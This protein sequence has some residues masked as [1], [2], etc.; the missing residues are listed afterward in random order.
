M[1]TLIVNLPAGP[2]PR[3]E[4]DYVLSQ[5][6]VSPHRQ[7]SAAATLLPTASEVIAVLPPQALS[8]HVVHLPEGLRLH[9]R[10]EPTRL[11]AALAGLIEEQLLDEPEQLHLAVFAHHQ[12]QHVWAAA[13]AEA[14]LRAQLDTLEAAGCTPTRVVPAYLPT[15][16]A[17]SASAQP[18]TPSLY[19]LGPDAA[20]LVLCHAQGVVTLPGNE[21]AWRF[22][23]AQTPQR[24]TA[25][26]AAMQTAQGKGGD[27]TL[28]TRAQ[29]LLGL[30]QSPCNLA[31]HRLA[32]S[33]ARRW[34]KQ[35]R[36][37]LAALWQSR[38]WRPARV[39]LALLMALNML[40]LSLV[41]RQE[42]AALHAKQERINQVLRNT[43]PDVGLVIDA[44]LQMA[45]AL[46]RQQGSTL[47]LAGALQAMAQA[48]PTSTSK[49]STNN[50]S[51]NAPS[52]T[53][54]GISALVFSPGDVRV[55]GLA[56][57]EAQ[58]K[59]LQSTLRGIGISAEVASNGDWL[60]TTGGLP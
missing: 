52:S 3:G 13:V 31:Q 45:R 22:M 47:D 34:Q 41:A 14:A 7:G 21:A 18:N 27:W 9:A 25:E 33:A 43:F 44:P 46:A 10:S 57:D 60:L 15:G 4:F 24:L 51:N 54:P 37:G 40:G 30:I 19:A 5:D 49:S 38:A 28:Q 12:P 6:G 1:S 50:A 2:Q 16:F 36:Q 20:T 58:R 59:R 53:Q 35:W 32:L 23:L 55:Q 56:L 8:W 48:T 39:G 29:H 17:A 42:Q 11:R 26:P